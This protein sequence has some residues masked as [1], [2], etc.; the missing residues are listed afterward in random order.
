MRAHYR[1]QFFKDMIL[2]KHQPPGPFPFV[3]VLDH[4]KP[5][6]NIGKIIR[7]ANAF[8]AREVHLVDIP[9]FNPKPCK[10]TLRQTRTR[11]FETFKASHDS[12]V[13]EGYTLFA[14]DAAGTKTLAETYLPQKSA[15]VV[16]HEEFGL[17][18]T[19]EEFPKVNRVRIP[20]FGQVQSLNASI[21]GAVICYEYLRQVGFRPPL[22]REAETPTLLAPV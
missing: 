20:Q 2:S 1:R 22:F 15:F 14:L 13:E 11:A 17:S 12:L 16:G 7:T 19:A 8:G 18:F 6:F 21:A 4:M 5:T 3:L 10:G 9:M